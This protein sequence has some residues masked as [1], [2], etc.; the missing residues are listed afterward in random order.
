[1]AALGVENAHNERT[2]INTCW[3]IQINEPYL[4]GYLLV[5]AIYPSCRNKLTLAENVRHKIVS[6]I[7]NHYYISGSPTI[8]TQVVRS[9]VQT[10]LQVSNIK[11][12]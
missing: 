10:N 8:S 12:A 11:T 1:M 5:M 3:C 7:K 6:L 2:K 4:Y 9:L